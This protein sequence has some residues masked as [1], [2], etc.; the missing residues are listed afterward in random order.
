MND[1]GSAFPYLVTNEGIEVCFGMTLLD[2]FAGQ[3]L[4]AEVARRKP[5]EMYGDGDWLAMCGMTA[6]ICYDYAAAMIAE[7]ERRAKGET[8]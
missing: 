8:T 2:W 6:S 7:R 1:G 3:A 5:G 4:M